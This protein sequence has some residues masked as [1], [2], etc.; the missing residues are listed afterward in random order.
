MG[1]RTALASGFTRAAK[2]FGGLQQ[3]EAMA[4]AAEQV[5]QMGPDH[6]FS[7]G[8]PVAPY[9]GYSRTPRTLDYQTSY[10][11]ATRPRTHERVS[12]DTLRGLVEA[13]DVASLCIWHRIDSIRSLDWKLVA[14]DGYNGDVAD[15]I[16]TG[17]KALQKPDGVHD[18]GTWFAKWA[19][20]VL[21]YDAG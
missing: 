20:D 16:A 4:Q 1:V 21:A 6:P 2:A 9:D 18:F 10:N 19:F 8:E 3:P 11:D 7:P 14:A 13:Y 5:S 12:F 17:M 15:A